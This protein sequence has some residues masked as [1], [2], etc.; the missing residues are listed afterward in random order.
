GSVSFVIDSIRR[1]GEPDLATSN[2]T[3][4]ELLDTMTQAA[5]L[6]MPLPWMKWNARAGTSGLVARRAGFGAREA[7]GKV[8]GVRRQ[9]RGSRPLRSP[10]RRRLSPD[11]RLVRTACTSKGGHLDCA[12]RATAACDTRRSVLPRVA[13]A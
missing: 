1:I 3:V 9:E 8:R 11:R 5:R 13:L 12:A 10:R 6:V 2:F 4:S 7:C